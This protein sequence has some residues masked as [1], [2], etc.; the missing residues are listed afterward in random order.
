MGDASRFQ[1]KVG[2]VTAGATGIGF[3]CARA[4]VEGGG[5]VM[6]CARREDAL[7]E[8]AGSAKPFVLPLE[9]AGAFP[10]PRDPRVVWVGCEPVPALELLQH[11]LEGKM[12]QLGFP[13]E[14][15]PFR[16]HLTAGRVKRD[17]QRS[18][19]RELESDL[20][21]VDLSA[22]PLM[23]SLDLVESKLGPR[24][25]SYHTRIAARLGG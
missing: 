15:R 8:V 18:A 19:F 22:A 24:R 3:G 9:G 2:I 20:E 12:Q 17:A 14:G 6:I 1:G 16:P 10:T 7:R 5:R 23:E 25:P 13:L 4:I 11:A 21:S